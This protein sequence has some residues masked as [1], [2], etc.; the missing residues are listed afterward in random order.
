MAPTLSTVI[1]VRPIATIV[2][3]ALLLLLSSASHAQLADKKV[4]TLAAAREMASAAEA[5]ALRN[6]WSLVIVIVDDAG[7]LLFMERMD[8]VQ[9]ASI[10]IATGKARTAALYRRPSK[11]FADRMAGGSWGVNLTPCPPSQL[12]R[13]NRLT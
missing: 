1:P 12:G 13:G 10:A 9:L 6:G 4:L 8:G 7:H 2:L 11:E 5:E 3:T